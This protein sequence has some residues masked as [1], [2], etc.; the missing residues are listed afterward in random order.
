MKTRFA[1]AFAVT[2]FSMTVSAA[3]ATGADAV[4]SSGSAADV[5]DRADPFVGTQGTGHMTPV[6]ATAA[7]TAAAA[8]QTGFTTDYDVALKR[9]AE[10]GKRTL[11]LFTG[12]DWCVWCKKLES[13]VFSKPEFLAA[14]KE[15]Y[16]LVCCDFPSK[17]KLPPELKKRNEELQKKYSVNG[18]PT[19]VALDKN[20]KL[21][22]TLGYKQ[23]G[24]EKWLE[25]AEKEIAAGG[26][27]AKFLKPFDDEF[28]KLDDETFAI[29]QKA[30]KAIRGVQ[31]EDERAKICKPMF[32]APLAKLKDFVARLRAAEMPESVAEKKADLIAAADH[33]I[34]ALQH[35][36]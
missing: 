5:L 26:D 36:P 10:Q 7:A 23:G 11:V 16:E 2:T 6:A 9:A 31:G 21:L 3:P 20:G 15:K 28:Q 12:S 18:F 27:V 35:E 4:L 32:E 24:A 30:Q 14:A 29:F 13:E 17:K 25:Y 33:V 19:V 22:A 34:F 8:A 1:V